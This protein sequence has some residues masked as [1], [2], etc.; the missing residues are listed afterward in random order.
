MRESYFHAMPP[1]DLIARAKFSS[2]WSETHMGEIIS[3]RSLPCG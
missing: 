2:L 3:Y 1:A